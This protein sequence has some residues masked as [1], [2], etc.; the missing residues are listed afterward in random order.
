VDRR[1]TR[2]GEPVAVP[3]KVFD[4]LLALLEAEGRLV[5]KDAL[6][7]RVWADTF[8]E[9]VNL[10]RNVSIL[11]KILGERAP[12]EPYIE[13]LPTRGYRFA[14][15]IVRASIDARSNDLPRVEVPPRD[16]RGRRHPFQESQCLS[17]TRLF[18]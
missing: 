9:E 5:Q 1:L 13:T 4:T 2:D 6:M 12:G 18:R 17:G 3:P 16:H 7:K 15:P 10:A 11:R 8:V 14:A